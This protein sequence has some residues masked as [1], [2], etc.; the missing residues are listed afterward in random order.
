MTGKSI[1]V[2]I[3][4]LVYLLAVVI[5]IGVA[6]ARR[7]RGAKD[8]FALAARTMGLWEVGLTCGL[9][10]L[11]AVHVTGFFEMSWFNGAATLWF[12][13][14]SAFTLAILAAT[15]GRW[16]RS[17]GVGTAY[18]LVG[19]ATGSQALAVVSVCVGAPLIWGVLTLETQGLGI[20]MSALTGVP[21]QYGV[22]IGAIIGILYVF[23]AGMKQVARLNLINIG[24]LYVG[25]IVAAAYLSF[26]L[27]QGWSGVSE[28]YVAQNEAWALSI[29]GPP[30]TLISFALV[31]LLVLPLFHL[32]NQFLL[33]PMISADSARTVQRSMWIAV[34]VNAAF[35]IFTCAMGLAAKTIPQFAEMGPKLA[36]PGMLVGLLPWWLCAWLLA[37]FLLV[38]L[39]TFAITCL[40]PSTAFVKDIYVN[41]LKPQATEKEVERA[42]RTVMLILAVAAVIPSMALPP[43]VAAILWLYAWSVPVSVSLVMGL[44]WKRSPLAS[45]ITW[46]VAWV[47]NALWSF[48]GLP[49]ALGVPNL[50]GIYIVLLISLVLGIILT[51]VCKGEPGYFLARRRP[52]AAVSA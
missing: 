32:S 49:A 48:T 26:A 41:L 40:A 7:R 52:A 36:A 8:E 33:Q 38:V 23:I 3:I 24:V 25:G 2:L 1:L 4:V 27:P 43:I 42:I 10:V 46:A 35:G 34:P 50:P 30:G 51:A 45:G 44:F 16:A 13:I 11:G 47:A 22:V 20:I 28:F 6:E 5:G 31:N 17:M 39:S 18:E 29:M 9:A 37:S 15:S 12:S 21:L 14:G 19:R